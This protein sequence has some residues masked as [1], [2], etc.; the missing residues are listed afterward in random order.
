M[1][2]IIILVDK[3]KF[4][5]SLVVPFFPPVYRIPLFELDDYS[6]SD[7]PPTESTYTEL[8]FYPKGNLI[9]DNGLRVRKY[10]E[11]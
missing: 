4:V 11:N 10:Y 5:K 7:L 9:D 6:V 8:N 1:T 2:N 3:K